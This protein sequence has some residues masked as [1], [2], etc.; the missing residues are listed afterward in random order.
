MT[1]QPCVPSQVEATCNER[2]RGVP[3]M[4]ETQ[5]CPRCGRELSEDA[6]RALCPAC[7]FGVALANPR[8]TS[9][10][11]PGSDVDAP[12]GGSNTVAELRQAVSRPEA[13]EGDT[14][15]LDASEPET[16]RWAV[17]GTTVGYFG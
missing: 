6:P 15:D 13:I 1:Q 16:K 9:D 12:G 5:A 7:L 11:T 17:G 4:T 14:V 8:D 3:P 10:S 2:N